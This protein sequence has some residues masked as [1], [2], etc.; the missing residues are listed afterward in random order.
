MCISTVDLIIGT[1]MFL[2]T[3]PIPAGTVGVYGAS[4]TTATCTTQG[5]FL[6]LAIM[7]PLYNAALSLYYLLMIRYSWSEE[8]LRKLR[9]P[10]HG[11][12]LVFGISTAVAGLPL[13]LYNNANLWCWQAPYPWGCLESSVNNGITTC[14]RGDN[15]TTVYRW[16]FFYAPLWAAIV[17]ATV[18]MTL[19]YVKVQ[20]YERASDRYSMSAYN[21]NSPQQRSFGRRKGAKTR[22][23]ARQALCYIGAFY[24]TWI[25]STLTRLT[26]SVSGNTYYWITLMTAIFLPFQGFLNFL[27]YMRPRYE[28]YRKQKQSVIA[29]VQQIVRQSLGSLVVQVDEEEEVDYNVAPTE[30]EVMQEESSKDDTPD[31]DEA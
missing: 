4:G 21:E 5:F 31:T 1:C 17:F 7:A 16:A 12:I 13:T 14:E 9:V 18:A 27:V 22:K 15:A 3:W 25:W 23:V 6:Q 29:A 2:S 26:Q 28:R 30:A 19:V 8:R 11:A 24:V 10:L 20:R